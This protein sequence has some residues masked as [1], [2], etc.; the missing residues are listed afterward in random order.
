M[1]KIVK[2]CWV[3]DSYYKTT[4]TKFLTTIRFKK[5]L[6]LSY[7]GSISFFLSFCFVRW[8]FFD[9]RNILIDHGNYMIVIIHTSK[10][11]ESSYIMLGR[12]QT[13]INIAPLHTINTQ[14]FPIC[15][16]INNP[17]HTETSHGCTIKYTHNF[18]YNLKSGASVKDGS[19]LIHNKVLHDQ[20]CCVILSKHT[21]IRSESSYEVLGRWQT[22]TYNAPLHPFHTQQFLVSALINKPLHTETSNGHTPSNYIHKLYTSR[23]Q[24][25]L[26][27]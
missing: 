10:R 21:S 8:I 17:R 6:R 9:P 25:F 18:Y 3:G 23:E 19:S 4:R 20:N 26:F 1:S 7:E 24:S 27:S 14:Q 11:S 12:C 22:N 2:K 16:L 13:I 15:A 5:I